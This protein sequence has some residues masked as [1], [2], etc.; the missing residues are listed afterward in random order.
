[1]FIA[2]FDT[3]DSIVADLYVVAKPLANDARFQ[4]GF[5]YEAFALMS[6]VGPHKSVLDGLIC[7]SALLK[8]DQQRGHLSLILLAKPF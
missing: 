8:I 7:K 4:L 1:M 3:P 6:R 2:T 5:A